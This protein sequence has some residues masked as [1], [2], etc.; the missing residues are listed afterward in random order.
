MLNFPNDG[1]VF[2][3][4]RSDSITCYRWHL[5]EKCKCM[6]LH[7]F[8]LAMITNIGNYLYQ[9]VMINRA[10]RLFAAIEYNI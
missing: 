8:P 2:L 10:H 4:F 5:N 6:R 1:F 7:G 9:N 3:S